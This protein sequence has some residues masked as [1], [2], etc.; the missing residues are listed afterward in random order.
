[1]TEWFKAS[2]TLPED[3]DSI[4]S[5]YPPVIPV[6]GDLTPFCGL[7]GQLTYPH[8]DACIYSAKPFKNKS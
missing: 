3:L 2:A 4:L 1:M 5:N 6:P 8:I 7:C